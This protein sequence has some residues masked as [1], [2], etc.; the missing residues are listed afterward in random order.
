MLT[1]KTSLGRK[2]SLLKAI[3]HRKLAQHVYIHHTNANAIA[4]LFPTAVLQSQL[5]GRGE[6]SLE[7][8]HQSISKL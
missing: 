2:A 3:N 8:C 5:H 7:K 1:K 6:N 4:E